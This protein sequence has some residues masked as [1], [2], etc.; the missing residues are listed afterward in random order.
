M[1]ESSAGINN[2]YTYQVKRLNYDIPKN[3]QKYKLNNKI[4]IYIIFY[5]DSLKTCFRIK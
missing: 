3:Q 5:K 4:Y 1:N 2:R